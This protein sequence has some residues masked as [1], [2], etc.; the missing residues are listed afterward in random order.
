MGGGLLT[1]PLTAWQV[2]AEL[3]GGTRH[4]CYCHQRQMQH[5]ET[6]YT[7]PDGC[8]V[9]QRGFRISDFGLMVTFSPSWTPFPDRML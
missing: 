1:G 7:P 8:V 3:R 2:K 5:A 9:A 6:V 4:T